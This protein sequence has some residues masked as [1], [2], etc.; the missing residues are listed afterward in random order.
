MILKYIIGVVLL[1]VYSVS[2]FSLGAK[3]QKPVDLRICDHDGIWTMGYQD[4]IGYWT[5]IPL[6]QRTKD[7]ILCHIEDL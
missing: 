2:M 5:D 6:K 7:W 4:K 1:C 3:Y